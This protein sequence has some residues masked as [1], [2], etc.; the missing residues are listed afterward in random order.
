MRHARPMLAASAFAFAACS[1]GDSETTA[2]PAPLE[3]TP[4]AWA[5]NDDQA[6]FA[7][8]SG[9]VLA[10]MR[11][12]AETAELLL[13]LPGDFAAG[14][15]PAMLLRAGSFMHGMDPVEVS[16][17]EGGTVRVGRIPTTGPVVD[18]LLG[19]PTPLTIEAEGQD[20]VMVDVDAQLQ[21]FVGNCAEAVPAADVDETAH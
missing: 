17:G 10:T 12:D 1:A 21:A 13:E 14:A 2:E 15:R 4:G 3:L 7:D 19:T 20:P 5:A 8:E 11:C 18:T 6:S 9:T 16:E